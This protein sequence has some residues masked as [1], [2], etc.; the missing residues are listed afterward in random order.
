MYPMQSPNTG[1]G[2]KLCAAP[3]IPCIGQDRK[4]HV[5]T[6]DATHTKCGVKVILKKVSTR[7]RT[8]LFS[9]YECTY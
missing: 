2:Q 1:V 9:C 7:D 3:E 4:V 8:M 5:C 6:A